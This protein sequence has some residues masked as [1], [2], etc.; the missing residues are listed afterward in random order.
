[1]RRWAVQGLLGLVVALGGYLT[2]LHVTGGTAAC[3]ATPLINCMRVLTS[4][5]SVVLG[6]PL[7]TWGALWALVGWAPLTRTS[8]WL[9]L[10]GLA[11]HLEPPLGG[12]PTLCDN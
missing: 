4:G 8:W 2:V 7:P 3:P 9:W 12:R 5:G 10:C 6:V 1:M 11:A